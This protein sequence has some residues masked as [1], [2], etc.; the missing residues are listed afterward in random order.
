MRDVAHWIPA[1]IYAVLIFSLSHQ[2][3]PPGASLLPDYVGHFL[4]YGFFSLT[5]AWG[6]TSGL[7]KPPTFSRLGVA[8]L[9]ATVYGLLDEVHQSFVPERSP[10]LQDLVADSLGAMVFLLLLY[11]VHRRWS[12]ERAG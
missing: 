12:F 7:R 6:V 2:S 11:L 1:A 3:S 4:E 5:L 8:W 9:L 10:T